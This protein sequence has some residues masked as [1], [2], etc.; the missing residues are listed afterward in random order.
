MANK[1]NEF[2]ITKVQQGCDATSAKDGTKC[3]CNTSRVHMKALEEMF[4]NVGE[5]IKAVEHSLS[6]L[7]AHTMDQ[8]NTVKE[9]QCCHERRPCYGW[10]Q[11]LWMPSR[12]SHTKLTS[13]ARR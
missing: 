6:V 9:E 5:R 8:L 1:E 13:F 10:R 3:E 12:P 11:R 4:I 7:E 2:G